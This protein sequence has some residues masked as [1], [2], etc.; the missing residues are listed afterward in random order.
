MDSASPVRQTLAVVAA[1]GSRFELLCVAPA[2]PWQRA[3]YWLPALGVSARHYLPLA[4]A[5][6]A[7]GIAVVI[8]EWRGMGSS[9]RR[10]SRHCN[11]GYREILQD[12]L[13]AAQRVL[14]VR[15][16]QVTWCIGGHSLGGQIAMLRVALA[17]ADYAGIVLVASGAPYWRQFRHGWLLAGMFVLAPGLAWLWGYLPGRQIRFGGREARGVIADW[18]RSGRSGR[19]AARGLTVDL[20]QALAAL[21]RPVLGLPL[22]DDWLAP[23]PS[24]QYLLDKTPLAQHS[25]QALGAQVLGVESAPHYAWMRAPQAV[26][27]HGARW[28]N[29]LPVPADSTTGA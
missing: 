20:E 1:D 14:R 23:M 6:A 12:D 8:H 3:L 26:A 19:F 4:E 17:P 10:A 13:P 28:I 29:T 27:A 18:A 5:M 24:L 22:A 7:R 11:W 9:S 21:R 2:G 15:W 16:P 25:V